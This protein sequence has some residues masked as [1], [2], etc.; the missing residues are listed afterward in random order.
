MTTRLVI[1]VGDHTELVRIDPVFPPIPSRA[2]DYSA[3][4][5]NYEPGQPIGYGPTEEAALADLRIELEARE[6]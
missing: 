2:F 4:T 5:D 6:P 3:A 1:V